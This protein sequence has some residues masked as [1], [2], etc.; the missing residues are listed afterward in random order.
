MIHML[1]LLKASWAMEFATDALER[2]LVGVD[3]FHLLPN[4]LKIKQFDTC[5]SSL[6]W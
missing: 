2:S 1:F 5:E 6:G 4:F 3:L